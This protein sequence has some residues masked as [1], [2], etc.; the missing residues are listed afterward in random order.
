MHSHGPPPAFPGALNGADTRTNE[1][2]PDTH[3][4]PDHGVNER[5][6]RKRKGSERERGRA[7]AER[8]LRRWLYTSCDRHYLYSI[9]CMS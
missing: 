5:K 3:R 7:G 2:S 9:M 1:T 6:K 4:A 8:A